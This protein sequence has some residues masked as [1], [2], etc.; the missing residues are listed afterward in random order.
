M[1][2]LAVD[3]LSDAFS[4]VFAQVIEERFAAIPVTAC[5]VWD[6]AHT[7]DAAVQHIASMLGLQRVLG[8]ASLRG[9]LPRGKAL[10]AQRGTKGGLRSAIEA[11]GFAVELVVRLDSQTCNGS[12]LAN[13]EPNRCGGDAFWAVCRVEVTAPTL[14]SEQ[15]VVTTEQVSELWRT[16][17]YFGRKSSRCVLAVFDGAGAWVFRNDSTVSEPIY[18]FTWATFDETFDSTFN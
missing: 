18:G 15:S 9:A 17:N 3:G 1:T 2:A 10:L 6:I 16:I 11:L 14:G 13:G 4:K 7:P 5:L 12:F 8:A